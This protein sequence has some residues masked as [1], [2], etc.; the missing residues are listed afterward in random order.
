M[1]QPDSSHQFIWA[2]VDTLWQQKI[3]NMHLQNMLPSLQFQIKMLKQLLT[4][5][6]RNGSANSEFLPKFTQT[7]AVEDVCEM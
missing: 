3:Y 5:F 6:L 2:H 4:Q 1:S 7:A